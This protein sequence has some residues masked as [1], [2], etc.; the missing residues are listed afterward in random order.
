MGSFSEA[1][2]VTD[3]QDCNILRRLFSE[4]LGTFVYISILL[5]GL[6]SADSAVVNALATGL[7]VASIVAIFGH[8]SGG[9][10]NPAITIGAL[11]CDQIT[12]LPAIFYILAQVIG[13]VLGVLVARLLSLKSPEGTDSLELWKKFGLETL[14]SFLLVSVAV[15]VPDFRRGSTGLAG[16]LAIG[17]SI[18]APLCAI[19]NYRGSMNPVRSLAVSMFCRD[20]T[21]H[22]VFWAGPILGGI[23]AGLVYRFILTVR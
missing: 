22:W 12:L 5:S 6:S 14:F 23:L 11:V 21:S 20:F 13:A 2:G 17:V 15:S 8:V 3:F 7:L 4:L 19:T 10:I 18:I 9:H 16:A 1:I